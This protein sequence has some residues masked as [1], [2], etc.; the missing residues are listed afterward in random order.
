MP[1]YAG[2]GVTIGTAAERTAISSPAAGHFFYETDTGAIFIYTGTAWVSP[3][4]T[5]VVQAYSGD[6]APSGWLMCA[7][8]AGTTVTQAAYPALWAVLTNNG[9]TYPFGGSGTTTYTPDLRGRAP[10]GKDNMGGTT[11]SRITAAG[12][13]ITGTTLGASG[14]VEIHTLT[15]AQMPSHTHTQDAHSHGPPP[16]ASNYITD[17]GGS[18]WMQS[19][20]S[21]GTFNARANTA[22]A[23]ATNQNTG[24]GGAHQNTP[25]AIILNYIIKT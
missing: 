6:T 24:G 20:G 8:T 5:G 25:P 21:F 14:G 2:L 7:G 13:G 4:P 12:S 23:T 11:A 22:G 9:A 17:G 18:A 1:S 19:S 10:F 15:T 3:T 16:G